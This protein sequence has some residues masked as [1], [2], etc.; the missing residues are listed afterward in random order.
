M[1]E[2]A[3]GPSR[4]RE[5]EGDP[6]RPQ[7]G[8]GVSSDHGVIPDR[9]QAALSGTIRLV[10]RNDNNSM[11]FAIPRSYIVKKP[12]PLIPLGPELVRLLKR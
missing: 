4:P 10:R 5:S 12:I 11:K 8:T 3:V 9:A 7:Q 2:P 1:L 6:A